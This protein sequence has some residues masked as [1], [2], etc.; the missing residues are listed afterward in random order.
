MANRIGSP[1]VDVSVKIDEKKISAK[2][3][4]LINISKGQSEQDKF[5]QI[6]DALSNIQVQITDS[7]NGKGAKRS[8]YYKV[9]W[10]KDEIGKLINKESDIP[11]IK[12]NL[13]KLSKDIDDIGEITADNE[14]KLSKLYDIIDKLIDYLKEKKTDSDGSD[15]GKILTI[16]DNIFKQ[17]EQI[18]NVNLK[19]DQNQGIISKTIDNLK[20]ISNSI[21]KTQKLG[22]SMSIDNTLQTN[23]R[24]NRSTSTLSTKIGWV[25]SGLKKT[26]SFVLSPISTIGGWIWGGIKKLSNIVG[27]V[28]KMCGELL[29]EVT[30]GIWKT[31]K[32]LI[33]TPPG[34]FVVGMIG[35]FLYQ[36]FYDKIYLKYLKE[37]WEKVKL[38]FKEFIN[39]DGTISEK[40]SKSIKKV[41]FPEAGDDES[42]LGLIFKDIGKKIWETL[43]SITIWKFTLGELLTTLAIYLGTKSVM[44][45]AMYVSAGIK[46]FIDKFK[47]PKPPTGVD[48]K[49]QVTNAQSA[50][51]NTKNEVR[52][53]KD[54]VKEQKEI[55]KAAD[56][57]VK[58][59]ISQFKKAS[60]L[61]EKKQLA[62]D[63]RKA[64]QTQ[65]QAS[66]D[67]KTSKELLKEAE[68]NSRQ[69]TK[70]LADAKKAEQATH[71]F[72]N[73]TKK[74]LTKAGGAVS[75][76][77]AGF[78]AADA[79]DRLASGETESAAAYGVI[80]GMETVSGALM[81][82][83]VGAP[84]G[85]AID[86]AAMT[87]QLIMGQVDKI[88]EEC[89][90]ANSIMEESSTNLAQLN[91][92]HIEFIKG[93]TQSTR[94]ISAL[95]T[96]SL[97]Q[98]EEYDK[99]YNEAQKE[100][101]EI[102]DKLSNGKLVKRLYTNQWGQSFEY[103]AR[104][105]L[106]IKEK[107]E[108]SERYNKLT[109]IM[110]L[111]SI[112]SGNLLKGIKEK[113]LEKNNLLMQIRQRFVQKLK[114]TGQQTLTIEQIREI[115]EE[116][117]DKLQIN[118]DIPINKHDADTI[119]QLLEDVKKMEQ[120]TYLCSKSAEENSKSAAQY[121]AVGAGASIAGAQKKESV[122]VESPS[123]NY[124]QPGFFYQNYNW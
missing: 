32:K 1:R 41:F 9:Q 52:A 55:K 67:L 62:Q 3:K 72:K 71:T 65:K 22:M 28:F 120:Q 70:T 87:G 49:T 48:L 23:E 43:Q 91:K 11:L 61:E 40:I 13:E 26:L 46:F 19:Q 98:L 95:K 31:L 38:F 37:P 92:E 30:S 114:E 122:L 53:G 96:T 66:Q 118:K 24:I 47:T 29:S 84:V 34:L 75:L 113:K 90:Q 116:S 7:I 42:I 108:L 99:T 112:Q 57:A 119:K 15:K 44:D 124:N 45:P 77:G 97:T 63:I 107:T 103:T 93:T 68:K 27:S 21:Q 100:L 10:I 74:I 39:A 82:T 73:A 5:K 76:V 64:Q 115:I 78:T 50:V 88:N 94:L 20:K 18:K 59:K 51:K 58:E 86:A 105:S 123:T 80:A 69:A 56:K 60:T 35:G 111:M 36:M 104:E 17:G 102:Q 83:G 109:T 8:N 81:M 6:I 89:K 101:S 12:E 33:F 2:G 79:F 117:K 4:S 16:L 110:Q 85:L 14:Y 54:L 106:S 121:S 25:T